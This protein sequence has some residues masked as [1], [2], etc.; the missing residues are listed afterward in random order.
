MVPNKGIVEQKSNR[1]DII[2]SFL[3]GIRL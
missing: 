3:K 2:K 1:R